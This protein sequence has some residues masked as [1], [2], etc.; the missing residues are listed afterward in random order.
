M[1]MIRTLSLATIIG[2]TFIST[3]AVADSWK[4]VQTV[5]PGTDTTLTQ[6]DTTTSGSVQA[7]NNINLDAAAGN[8][9]TDS[10]QDVNIGAN[11]LTLTQDSATTGSTQAANSATANEIT[12]LTQTIT[13][14]GA[15]TITL[16]Q[17]GN[18]GNSNTQAVNAVDVNS[19]AAAASSLTQNITAGT[20]D[21]SMEQQADQNTQAGNLIGEIAAVTD[22]SATQT[23]AVNNA[24]MS[25]E[26]TTKGFQAGN[27]LLTD[28]GGA[29]GGITQ[30]LTTTGTL[31]MTQTT[32]DNSQQSGN[33]TG[34]VTTN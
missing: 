33:Y 24:T 30:T 27:A 4:V 34:V 18:V 16:E 12:E 23:V 26:A 9:D 8:I 3:Q 14:T 32:A 5:T 15:G 22:G 7:L 20:S 19:I 6:T 25:Q 28:T 17:N 1:K 11:N 21:L 2:A 31:E 10:T 13:S 29:G